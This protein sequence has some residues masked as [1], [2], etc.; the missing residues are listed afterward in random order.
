MALVIRSGIRLA[1]SAGKACVLMAFSLFSAGKMLKIRIFPNRQI[2]GT[3]AA[4][5]IAMD[6]PHAYVPVDFGKLESILR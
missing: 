1:A 4:G 6:H 5:A 2:V 3:N